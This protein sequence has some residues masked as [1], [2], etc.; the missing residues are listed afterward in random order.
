MTSNRTIKTSFKRTLIVAA[1][2][3]GMAWASNAYADDA[4]PNAAAGQTVPVL[5]TASAHSE[6]SFDLR[7][8]G[9]RF[10]LAIEAIEKEALKP[11]WAWDNCEKEDRVARKD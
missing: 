3:I 4:S 5:S 7:D 8:H 11:E 2:T 9:D 10:K 1:G 6:R